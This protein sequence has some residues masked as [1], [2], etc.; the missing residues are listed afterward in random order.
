MTDDIN[1]EKLVLHILDNKTG[2][3]IFSETEHPKDEDIYEFLKSHIDKVFRDVNIKKAYLKDENEVRTLCEKLNNDREA[4]LDVSS[5]LAKKLYKVLEENVSIPACDLFC[6]LFKREEIEFLGMFILNYKTTYIHQV[7]NKEDVTTNK[8]IKQITTLPSTSQSIDEFLVIDLD[9]YSVMLKEK[10]YEIDGLKEFY[11]SRLFLK[12]ETVL[13]DKE[14]MDIVNKTTKKIVKD[15]YEG[16]VKK[17]AEVKTAIAESIEENDTIDID[18]I[19]KTTFED[20]LELQ[21]IYTEE[22]EM[23]G[24][25][26]KNFQVNENVVKKIPKK[27]KLVTEDGIEI[28]IPIS[29]LNSTEKVEFINNVDGTIS[30]LLKNI[31]DIQDK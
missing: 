4:F 19:K 2:I 21:E 31:R 7:E 24:L 5:N 15:Y 10:R 17:I 8:V 23:K 3:P 18:H 22:L 28:K 9:D 13:S 20:N 16:D 12:A 14:K 30:I 1:L 26:E 29:Y 11:L 25:T 6:V 27:Q